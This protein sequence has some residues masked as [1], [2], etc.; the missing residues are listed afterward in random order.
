M[1]RREKIENIQ[2]TILPSRQVGQTSS[3]SVA[4]T[5]SGLDFKSSRSVFLGERGRMPNWI[6]LQTCFPKNW[7]LKAASLDPTSGRPRTT[8]YGIGA[9]GDR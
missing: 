8:S 5:V 6:S 9:G 4:A 2:Q 7:P 3:S 1:E